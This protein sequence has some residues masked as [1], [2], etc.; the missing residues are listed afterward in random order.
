MI[1]SIDPITETDLDSY[2]DEQLPV[3]RRI[4]VEAYLARNPEVAAQVMAD[5]C[6]RDSLRLMF[7]EVSATG[8]PATVGAA[9]KLDVALAQ[10]RTMERLPRMAAL[11]LCLTLGWLAHAQFGTLAIGSVNASTPPPAYLQDA[12][13]VYRVGQAAVVEGA[14]VPDNKAVAYE[15][16]K[17]RAATAI[18]LPTLPTH[19]TVKKA[20]IL[21]SSFG[22]SV[23]LTL[24]AGR[25]GPASLFAIRPGTFDVVPTTTIQDNETAAFWQ[26]GE[27]AYVLVARTDTKEVARAAERLSRT[28]Y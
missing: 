18:V 16:D 6:A 3:E 25:L 20:E 2:V 15:P 17:I 21:T 4:E 19:W 26:V 5:L 23:E 28:L 24:D 8:A 1:L 13:E 27:V 10:R 12:L 7:D 11:V 9:R 14:K 22:P